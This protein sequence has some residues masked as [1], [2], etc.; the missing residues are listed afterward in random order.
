MLNHN[1]KAKQF[2]Q[3]SNLGAQ[4]GD[5]NPEILTR[6]K[7]NLKKMSVCFHSDIT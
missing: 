3:N 4:T 1:G 7:G 6:L 2:R 5:D